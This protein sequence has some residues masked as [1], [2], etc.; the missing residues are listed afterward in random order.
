MAVNTYELLKKRLEA[1]GGN[2]EGRM[3]Q[4]KLKS[5]L[6][7]LKYSEQAE[8]VIKDGVEYRAI[9][10]K[11]KQKMDYDDKNISIPFDAE[12]K[13][14]DVF[15][16]VEDNSD[17]IIYLKEGQDAYFTGVCRKALYNIKWKDE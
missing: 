10:N 6:D 4:G 17:W 13:V 2:Q 9:L 11:N 7:A 1:S 16:W 5:L 15:H 12:F 8:T 14:G 3:R